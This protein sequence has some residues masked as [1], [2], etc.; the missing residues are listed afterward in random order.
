MLEVELLSMPI[1]ADAWSGELRRDLSVVL[2]SERAGKSYSIVRVP[3]L[4]LGA[5]ANL[6]LHRPD[7]G[8]ENASPTENAVEFRQLYGR[9]RPVGAAIASFACENMIDFAV[10]GL[11]T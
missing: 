4:F 5:L 8:E 10:R 1:G 9:Q 6:L 3:E 11:G 7:G 2:N